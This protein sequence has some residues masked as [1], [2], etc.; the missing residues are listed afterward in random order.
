MS[1]TSK[2][3]VLAAVMAGSLL[4][5]AEA[6]QVSPAVAKTLQSAQNASKARKWA[7][8]LADLRQADAN[9]GKTAYDG[10]IINELTAF[11]ALSANDTATALRAY[12]ANLGSQYLGDKANAR[13]KDLTKLHFNARNYDKAIEFGQR[14]I[15]E[16]FGDADTSLVVAQSFY[17]KSDFKGARAF[18]GDW[19]RDQEKRGQ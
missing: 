2:F 14:A 16:G 6:Q 3:V 13:V 1:K 18:V 11:C 12:E 15:K 4:V 8:C 10:F 7:E 5:T 19:I 17:Q 9:P